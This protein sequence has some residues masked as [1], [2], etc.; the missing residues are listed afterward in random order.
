MAGPAAPCLARPTGKATSSPNRRRLDQEVTLGRSGAT[1]HKTTTHSD[2]ECYVQRDPRSQTGSVHTVAVMSART[3]SNDI[4]TDPAIDS[5]DSIN[6][7]DEFDEGS[8]FYLMKIQQ[9]PPGHHRHQGR[10]NAGSP[11]RFFYRDRCKHKRL[12]SPQTFF[13]DSLHES[14]V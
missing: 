10:L 5:E 4:E 13:S 12:G 3:R 1:V 9:G 2:A 11:E 7:D 8:Q 14:S 6:R